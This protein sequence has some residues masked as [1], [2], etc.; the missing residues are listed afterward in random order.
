[1]STPQK[2]LPVSCVFFDRFER[3]R[4][5]H[6]LPRIAEG[7]ITGTALRWWDLA[8]DQARHL[9]S[10]GTDIDGRCVGDEPTGLR[11]S[12]ELLLRRLAPI[13]AW[14]ATS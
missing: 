6:G 9:V 3:Q 13:E 12:A 4:Y 5:W 10:D 7:W 14:P 11:K 1:M 8:A 2:P